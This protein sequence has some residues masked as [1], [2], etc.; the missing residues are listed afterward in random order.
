MEDYEVLANRAIACCHWKWLNGMRTI[1][2]ERIC[3]VTSSEVLGWHKD[4]LDCAD[5]MVQLVPFKHSVPVPDLTDPATLGC[6]EQLVKDAYGVPHIWVEVRY[7]Q[8]ARVLSPDNFSEGAR[9]LS[10]WQIGTEAAALVA[11]LEAAHGH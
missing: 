10:E 11:A 8:R 5:G 3:E 2:G 7:G 9:M 4:L 6:L 1:D